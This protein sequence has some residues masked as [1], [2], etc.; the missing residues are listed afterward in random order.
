[1]TE[2]I[3]VTETTVVPPNGHQNAGV[4]NGFRPYKNE[5]LIWSP[6]GL[7]ATLMVA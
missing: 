2:T 3:E 5:P 7:G 6:N 4:K 1:M